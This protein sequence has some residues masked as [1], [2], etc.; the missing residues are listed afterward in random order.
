[1]S[2]LSL[3][4]AAIF[5]LIASGCKKDDPEMSAEGTGDELTV[6][7]WGYNH[8]T[9]D[10]EEASSKSISDDGTQLLPLFKKVY[11]PGSKKLQ[12]ILMSF[13][14]VAG[15]GY[16]PF[17]LNV[18]YLP[19]RTV[20]LRPG[21]DTAAIL[22]YSHSGK[23]IRA[24]ASIPFNAGWEWKY[25][26][27]FNYHDGNL[28]KIESSELVINDGVTFDTI[29]HPY[30]RLG[31]DH[32]K[33]NVDEISFS[34]F[35]SQTGPKIRYSYNY[36]KKVK[37]QVYP[38]DMYGDY[39]YFFFFLKNIN[40]LPDLKPEHLLIKSQTYN[41]EYPGNFIRKYSNHVIHGGRVSFYK[42]STT[43]LNPSPGQPSYEYWKLDWSCGGSN[44]YN[45]Q[46]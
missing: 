7:G 28:R 26:F 38:D 40:V 4:W 5:I 23:L 1:M 41:F 3:L 2:K 13:R 45:S 36:S 32:T 29:W 16:D 39:H 27:R 30:I 22:Y 18:V 11:Q 37:Y 24:Q 35:G 10:Y 14:N 31:Y 15:V 20:F 42:Q 6:D 33:K 43:L 25:S 12:S 17:T 9:C 34:S 44:H 21:G 46:D 8:N 19:R